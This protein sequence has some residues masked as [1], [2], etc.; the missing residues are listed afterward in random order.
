M[1]VSNLDILSNNGEQYNKIYVGDKELYQKIVPTSECPP[2][3]FI[4]L[5]YPISNN[6][7]YNSILDLSKLDTSKITNGEYLFEYFKGEEIKN[8]NFLDTS[9]FDTMYAMFSNCRNIASLKGVENWDTHKNKKFGYMFQYCTRITS[10]DL[11]RWDTSSATSTN[12]MFYNCTSL[13]SLDLSGWDV[14]KVTDMSGMLNN[15]SHLISLDLSGWDLSGI[16]STSALNGM[17]AYCS[18]LTTVI[19]SISGIKSNITLSNSPLTRE[20]ALVFINGLETITATRTITFSTSTK[21]LLT[22]EDIAIATNKG[23]TVK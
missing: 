12:Y 6:L 14:S 21:A 1:E 10:L 18:R 22:E 20:S 19:G 23:W 3:S 4:E 15:C 2:E 7:F 16:T 17:F 5:S 13:T 9:N 11:S 8:L